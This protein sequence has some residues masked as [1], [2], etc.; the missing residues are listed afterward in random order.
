MLVKMRSGWLELQAFLV[1]FFGVGFV[2]AITHSSLG[3]G[4]S[5]TAREV[6]R[7]INQQIENVAAV[8]PMDGFHL[9]RKQLDQFPVR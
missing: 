3:S 2:F 1:D 5:T 9:Y 4:K 7:L 8:V 6:V